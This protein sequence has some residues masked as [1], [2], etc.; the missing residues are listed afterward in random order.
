MLATAIKLIVERSDG[1]FTL[2]EIA[3]SLGVTHAALYRHFKNRQAVLA[4]IAEAGTLHHHQ[5]EVSLCSALL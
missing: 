3:R 5:N 2:S 4:A 1:N